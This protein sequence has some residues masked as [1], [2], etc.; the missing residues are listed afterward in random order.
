[1]NYKAQINFLKL[2][3]IICFFQILVEGK[4]SSVR[5]DS[6]KLLADEDIVKDN[7]SNARRRE[8]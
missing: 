7:A 8:R 6:T 2:L 5:N 4:L 1:M 3:I